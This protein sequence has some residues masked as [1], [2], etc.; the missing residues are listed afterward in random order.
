MLYSECV[1]VEAVIFGGFDF[2]F[3]ACSRSQ[4]ENVAMLCDIVMKRM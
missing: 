2:D 4:L 1:R 3:D